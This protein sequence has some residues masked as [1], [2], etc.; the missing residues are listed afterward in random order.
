MFYR[1]HSPAKGWSERGNPVLEDA[2]DLPDFLT[3]ITV[4]ARILRT[5]QATGVVQLDPGSIVT[6]PGT[7]LWASRKFC[8][9]QS[10]REFI[11][12]DLQPWKMG[13]TSLLTHWKVTALRLLVHA[14][15]VEHL[16]S[17]L[18]TISSSSW[19]YMQLTCKALS[20]VAKCTHH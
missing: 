10:L 13:D 20:S 15:P 17:R 8:L 3:D 4:L 14:F 18:V 12:K 6:D 9:L 7:P 11:P 5:V 19:G 1:A 16:E 2:F